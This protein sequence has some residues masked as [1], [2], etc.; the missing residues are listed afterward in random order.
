VLF[1]SVDAALETAELALAIDPERFKD[2]AIINDEADMR[3]GFNIPFG[4][5]MDERF[6][7]WIAALMIAYDQLS[8]RYRQA[9]LRFHA[10]S[11]NANQQ[12]V[13]TSFDGRR[14]LMTIA[15]Q[16]RRDLLKVSV[17][18]IYEMFKL[19]GDGHGAWVEGG[20]SFYPNSELFHLITTSATQLGSVFAIYPR[21]PSDALR[22]WTID[23]SLLE[24]PWQRVNVAAF[25][26]DA[27]H[28]NAYAAAGGP[29]HRRPF[30]NSAE[31]A[32]VRSA[33]ELA[34]S[35]PIQRNVLLRSGEFHDR[36]SLR[37]YAVIAYW[38]T[39]YST[40][41]P[42]EPVW[43]QPHVEDGNVILRW[44]PNLEPFFYSYEVYLVRNDEVVLLSP[45]P[46]RSAMWVDTAPPRG[47]RAYAVRAVSASGINSDL[48]MSPAIRI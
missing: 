41:P 38:I 3:V 10:A 44:Q 25:L 13:Q 32:K 42:A 40:E 19:L 35:A 21:T 5:R 17:F 34:V 7:A 28:S 8:S 24:I 18:N 27:Q 2:L 31:A 37:P 36:F 33:Q 26:I 23:Y 47:S 29:E 16:S 39:A 45:I 9:G 22:A 20:E 48:V 15:S 6:S 46:L 30:V 1:R 4:S 43:L 11:D 12:L 14:S